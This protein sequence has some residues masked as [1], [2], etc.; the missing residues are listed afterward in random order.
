MDY[1]LSIENRR[2]RE[3]KAILTDELENVQELR[4]FDLQ[5]LKRQ[6]F[7]AVGHTEP[8]VIR[9]DSYEMLVSRTPSHIKVVR[10]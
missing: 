8:A 7:N 6:I 1:T 5:Q 4:S 10:K 2:F 3:K 9:T